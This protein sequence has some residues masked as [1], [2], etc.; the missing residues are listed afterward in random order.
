MKKIIKTTFIIFVGLLFIWPLYYFTT[1]EKSKEISYALEKPEK[2]DIKNFVM[3][4][5]I[6]VPKEKVEIKSRVSGVLEEL[7]VKNGD[8][9][10][11]D[12]VI[13]KIGI[14]PNMAELAQAE[15]NKNVAVINYKNQKVSF[16]R[17][18][19][20]FE[21]G[22]ISRVDF[23]KVENAYLNA[24][25]TLNNA[26][27]RYRIVKSGNYSNSEKSNTSI[28]STIDGIVTLLPTEIGA[29]I[30]QSN[31]FNEGTT[32][33]QIA[34]VKQM[35]FEGSVKEYEVAKLQEGMDVIINSSINN[36]DQEGVLSEISTSGKNADGMILFDIKTTLSN[37]TTNKTGFSANAKIVVE[38]R[39]NAVSIKEEWL[40]VE[41]D[42][43][44]VLVHKGADQKEKRL[45]KLGLSDGVY[46]EVITGLSD[47][48][49]LRIYDK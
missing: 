22:I 21:K 10:Y 29:S 8:R 38:E 14:I 5:G 32:I 9:V 24:Q 6:V 23:E 47:N 19:T 2:K 4:S 45:V 7:Y 48:E 37:L 46:T 33:A 39:K 27:K 43:T 1:K 20:L 42:S 40:I 41:G 11:K 13:A 44:Y 30:I 18:K 49:T 34:N 26:R 12:Q 3:C 17:N 28:V 36:E 35:I 25:E 16:E 31:N 15:S